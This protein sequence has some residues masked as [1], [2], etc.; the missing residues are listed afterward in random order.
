MTGRP[1]KICATPGPQPRNGLIPP[2]SSLARV[3]CLRPSP[4]LPARGRDAAGERRRYHRR[5]CRRSHHRS[6]A[7]TPG[8]LYIIRVVW[9]RRPSAIRARL[10]PAAA[11]VRRQPALGDRQQPA[12]ACVRRRSCK[13]SVCL[14]VS[15]KGHV[16]E[17]RSGQE[18]SLDRGAAEGRL[19]LRGL[20]TR[21]LEP[22]TLP[23]FHCHIVTAQFRGPMN[24]KLHEDSMRVNILCRC[25]PL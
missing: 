7:A 19:K 13:P 21:A 20:S 6:K 17:G 25:P 12:T 23:L 9:L 1:E 10:R 5:D 15:R 11:R 22:A 4:L 16:Y 24:K 3:P 2:C 18:V 8:V 14:A